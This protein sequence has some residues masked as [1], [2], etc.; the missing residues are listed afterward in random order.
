VTVPAAAAPLPQ[1][2][3]RPPAVGRRRPDAFLIAVGLLTLTSIWRIHQIFPILGALQLPS[4][5]ALGAYALFFVTPSARNRL[6]LLK[7][8]IAMWAIFL[9][10]M[11]LV[12][13]VG[14]I[15]PSRTLFFITG[16]FGKTLLMMGLVIVAVRTFNDFEWML[17]AQVLGAAVYA[18]TILTRFSVDSTGRLGELVY[19]DSNDLAML[20]VMAL[21]LAAYFFRGGVATNRR[22]IALAAFGIIVV[23]LVKTG[24]RGGFLGFIAV[25]LFLL[26]RFTALSRKARMGSVVALVSGF[27]LVANEQYWGMMSTLLNPKA[28]YNFSGQS[29]GGRME[30]WKRGIGYMASFPLTGV[31]AA[32]FGIAEGSISSRARERL[33]A[34]QGTQQLAPHNSYVMAAAEL[35]VPGLV[36]F[37]AILVTGLRSAGRLVRKRYRG[38]VQR[39]QAA[40]QSLVGSLIGFLVTGFFLSQTYAALLYTLLGFVVALAALGGNA[41]A[42]PRRKRTRGLR[43]PIVGSTPSP[44]PG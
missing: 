24:S 23:G 27:L 34:G 32:N 17:A 3:V 21:P 5:S 10:F 33:A 29:E 40:A 19:Y 39:E 22:L 42:Q 37:V 4:L 15:Y 18:G 41:S 43:S 30:I 44:L 7:H 25:L 2:G 1:G 6:K 14:G 36:A 13:V 9:L 16:D 26:F 8:P 20:L 12:S 35:G 28:D 38:A 31:G 11:A